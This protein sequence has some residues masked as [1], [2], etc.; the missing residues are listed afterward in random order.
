MLVGMFGWG[1][2]ELALLGI[3]GL[4]IFGRRLPDVGRNL[5]RGIVEFKKGLSGLEDE[6]DKAGDSNNESPKQ[7][8]RDESSTQDVSSQ[9]RTSVDSSHADKS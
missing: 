9:Q 4:L 3:V 7:I 8:Q 6:I 1:M 5:G 2:W